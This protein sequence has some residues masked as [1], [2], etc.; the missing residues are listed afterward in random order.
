ME[1]KR[2]HDLA[3]FVV[4]RMQPQLLGNIWEPRPRPLDT[5]ISAYMVVWRSGSGL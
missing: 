4:P 1:E 2:T 3:A 5:S